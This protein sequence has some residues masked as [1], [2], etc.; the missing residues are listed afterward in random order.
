MT[1]SADIPIVFIV[2]TGRCG[3]SLLQEALSRHPSIGFLSNFDDRFGTSGRWN[4]RLYSAVP[5]RLTRKGRMRFA[6]SEGYRLLDR[7]VSPVISR[8]CR[9]LTES[10]VTPWVRRQL[11]AVFAQRHSA[12]RSA[13]FLHKFTG[14]PRAGFLKEVFPRARFIHVVRDGRAVSNSLLQMPW[15]HGWSGPDNWRLGRLPAPYAQLWERHDRSFVVLAGLYWRVLMDAHEDAQ[16]RMDGDGAWTSVRY[17]DLVAKPQATLS[18]LL[19]WV[20]LEWTRTSARRMA[21]YEFS[22]VRSAA[23][24]R[25]L[26]QQQLQQLQDVLFPTLLRYGYVDHEA[27]TTVHVTSANG[28][29]YR[30]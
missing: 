16:R 3:S 23:F 5:Q 1:P 4:Q 13:L 6:P 30:A 12:Q 15:W 25:D 10:D 8:T 21:A 9:D 19:E 2:G 27:P 26:S 29:Q 22:P 18:S 17:E 7:Q 24:R 14:W 28:D 20:G 11:T